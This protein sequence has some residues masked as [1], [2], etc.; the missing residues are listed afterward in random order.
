MQPSQHQTAAWPTAGVALAAAV[1]RPL[2]FALA[3][4]ER[5]G[6]DV[7][8]RYPAPLWATVKPWLSSLVKQGFWCWRLSVE[9]WV[10]RHFSETMVKQ[11]LKEFCVSCTMVSPFQSVEKFPPW[12]ST[13]ALTDPTQ[14][15]LVVQ[16][17]Q[18]S[19][20]VCLTPQLSWLF[21]LP[22]EEVCGVPT[23]SSWSY[24]GS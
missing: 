2:C 19:T 12:H 1:P 11:W 7:L 6:H 22:I 15:I 8:P 18:C 20:S 17:F 14:P 16:F 9:V 5:L 23:D 3:N 13:V 24:W 4:G 21:Q 10:V